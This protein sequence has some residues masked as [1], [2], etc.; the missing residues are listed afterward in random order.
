M[1]SQSFFL[2]PRPPLRTALPPDT[3]TGIA[4]VVTPVVYTRQLVIP[5]TGRTT[6]QIRVP[7]VE[8]WMAESET[9]SSSNYEGELPTISLSAMA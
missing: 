1:C 4:V 9:T 2:A 8:K 3:A 5:L 7:S 6:V